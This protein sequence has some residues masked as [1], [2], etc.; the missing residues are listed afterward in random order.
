MAQAHQTEMD[1]T[2]RSPLSTASSGTAPTPCEE[3]TAMKN[4]I[5]RLRIICNEKGKTVSLLRSDQ[6]HDESD[7]LY[8]LAW[9]EFQDVQGTLQQAEKLSIKRKDEEDFEFPPLRKTARKT[10]LE[11]SD[12]IILDN[13]FTLLPNVIIKQQASS[14]VAPSTVNLKKPTV[15]ANVKP[16]QGT[17][18]LPPPVMMKI[19]T[20]YREQ[21]DTIKKYFPHL[22]LKT[23]GDYIKLYSN[24]DE[25]NTAVKHT[26]RSLGYKFYVITPKNERPIK[27]VIKGFPKTADPENIKT[28]LEAEG[29][30]PDKVTQLIGR[31]TKQKL[32]I[33]L[34]TLPRSIE[35]LKIFDLKTLAH[36]NITVDGYNGKECLKC[37]EEHLTK[38][39]PIKQRLETKFCIN[40]QVYGHMA[41]WHGCPCFPKPPKG[42]AKTNK[43]TYTNLY[44]S[45]LR[46]NLSYAQVTNHSS[47]NSS[48]NKQ[49]MA[50]RRAE[51]SRQTEAV[52]IVPTIHNQKETAPPIINSNQIPSANPN[53]LN[54]SNNN[55]IKALLSTT[56]QC[57]IQLLNAMNST[58]NL[59][60][61]FNSVNSAQADANQI[62][63]R[64][65]SSDNNR[66][67]GGTLIL[68]KNAINHYSLPTPP[69]QTIE[70]TVVILTPLDHDPI[71]IVSV[72]VP[73]KSDEFTF[74]IDIE[75]LIQTSSNCVLFG[76]FNA[77]HTAWNCNS[78]SSRGTRLLDYTNLANL[79]IA[80][81]DTPTRAQKNV[82]KELKNYTNENWTARLQALNTQDNSLWA[83][84][85]FFKN[86]RSDIPSLHCT[87]GTAI[88]DK[89]KADI[90]AESILNNFTENE[91][92]NND[93]DD[94]DEIVNN[95]VNAFLSHPPLPP[96]K[97]LIPLR[98]F[99]I[100]KVLTLKGA[101]NKRWA[102]QILLEKTVADEVRSLMKELPCKLQYDWSR[103]I[104]AESGRGNRLG[105]SGN[106]RPGTRRS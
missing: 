56:V 80:Y 103:P 95:T 48:Q 81:P 44:N 96:L 69:L 59:A 39:C 26:L 38:D 61:N 101:R 32:P 64:P 27:I 74:T 72:Y 82:K 24:T 4:Y 62:N 86:K 5:R 99:L 88:T 87:T 8:Q 33:F 15:N 65:T 11:D 90:L 37:G 18:A 6:G 35:N 104:N 19:T 93:F 60:N 55:D 85:K 63:D 78:N 53:L 77:P 73:P 97:R 40:C 7:A 34:V 45:F 28:D 84:Q 10:I 67:S 89:Q 70:A 92:Q 17:N 3:L 98:S 1:I 51:T 13:Q 14:Q 106:K 100:S 12:D 57:L 16:T 79:Y 58:P 54:S 30:E 105:R 23:T 36:L 42:A 29:F 50:P 75:N 71:S 66:A 68:V 25:Q 91:R 2:P 20:T 41:N 47:R 94:D 102:G 83:V 21:V 76:D 31:R 22:R 46:P 9:N 49:Q 52:N 43:N